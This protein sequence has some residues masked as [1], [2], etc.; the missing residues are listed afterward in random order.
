MAGL[1]WLKIAVEVVA[2][3]G[4][5]VAGSSVLGLNISIVLCYGLFLYIPVLLMRLEHCR[6]IRCGRAWPTGH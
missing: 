1:F 5:V 6:R 4:R 2:L 3:L